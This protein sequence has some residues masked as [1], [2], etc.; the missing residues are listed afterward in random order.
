M[1]STR[2]LSKAEPLKKVINEQ[3]GT[4]SFEAVLVEDF[5]APHAYDEVIKGMNQSFQVRIVHQ[6]AIA[7]IQS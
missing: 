3:Y 6:E 7:E 2:N 1:S 5:A 4:G